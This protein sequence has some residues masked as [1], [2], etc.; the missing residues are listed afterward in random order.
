M[1]ENFYYDV[2]I[3]GGSYSGLSAA[4]ALGRSLKT[5]LILD[6]GQ[7]CNIQTPHSHNFLTQDGRK[8]SEISTIGKEQVLKYPTVSFKKDL[9]TDAAKE[10]DFFKIST[11]SGA[12]YF[13]KRILFATGIKDQ[14]PDII[15][16]K[17]CWGKSVIHC[18]YC[19]GYEVKNQPTAILANGE[20]AFL[21]SLFLTNWTDQLTLLTH[22]APTLTDS[23]KATLAEKNIPIKENKIISLSHDGGQ[24]A[25]INF[26]DGTALKVSALYAKI[27]YLQSCT[28][29][30]KLGCALNDK[31]FLVVDEKQATTVPGIYAAG[32]NSSHERA[33]SIA[34]AAGTRAGAAINFDLV[35]EN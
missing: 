6:S 9:V 23:Q 19:H 4:M 24:I 30:E 33:V 17:E 3:V 18:P 34:V 22:G 31:G 28:L 20:M 26:E 29:P 8:P 12:S 15:G 10:R 2:I 25:A 21:F 7:P 5:V 35:M 32:D 27:P 13:G 11:A 14:M 1:K 16:F